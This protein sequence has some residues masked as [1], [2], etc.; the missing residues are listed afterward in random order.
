MGPGGCCGKTLLGWTR[1]A[2]RASLRPGCAARGVRPV[3]DPALVVGAAAKAIGD[4]AD[5]ASGRVRRRVTPRFRRAS[6][7]LRGAGLLSRLCRGW[8]VW[9]IVSESS[10]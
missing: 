7:E 4:V 10:A 3:G 2:E 6:A 9:R 5:W 1:R 8:G